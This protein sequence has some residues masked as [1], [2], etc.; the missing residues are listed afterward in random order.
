VGGLN[1]EKVIKAG[2]SCLIER[3][4]KKE[5]VLYGFLGKQ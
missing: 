3:H 4:D 5:L 2:E 1:R